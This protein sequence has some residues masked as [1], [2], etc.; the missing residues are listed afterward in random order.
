LPAAAV[1]CNG[2]FGTVVILFAYGPPFSLAVI[3]MLVLLPGIWF[4]GLGLVIQRDLGGRGRPSLSSSLAGLAAAVTVVL[5][6]ALIP[7]LGVMGGALA[8]VVAYTTF[9]NASL[10][11]LHHVSGIAVRELIVPTRQDFAI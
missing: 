2:V 1:V 8:S 6:L 7:P 9:G 5:D 3:P 11:A 4:L 10:I